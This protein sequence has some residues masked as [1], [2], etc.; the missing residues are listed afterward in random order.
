M[1]TLCEQCG[2][3]SA[4]HRTPLHSGVVALHNIHN[5]QYTEHIHTQHMHTQHIHTQHTHTQHM[6]TQHMHTQHKHT[7]HIHTQHFERIFLPVW[8]KWI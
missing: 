2:A 7:Q 3:P 6:H 1:L 4:W 5:I 8:I